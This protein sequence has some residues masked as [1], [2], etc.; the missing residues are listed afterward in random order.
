[1][2][3]AIVVPGSAGKFEYGDWMVWLIVLMPVEKQNG[4]FKGLQV[5]PT[6]NQQ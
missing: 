2:L 3:S 6:M 5:E 1:M 4:S